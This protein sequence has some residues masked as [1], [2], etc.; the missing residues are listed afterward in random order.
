MQYITRER[1]EKIVKGKD[2]IDLD[3]LV[4]VIENEFGYSVKLEEKNGINISEEQTR[5]MTD[6]IFSNEDVL[7]Q[8]HESSK[9]TD[10]DYIDD[11]EEFMRLI[12]EAADNGRE[13]ESK[14]E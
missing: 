4:M 13:I 12:K 7:K 1:F 9:E 6:L 3:E 5:K 14:L 11:E 2:K 10:D 8:L